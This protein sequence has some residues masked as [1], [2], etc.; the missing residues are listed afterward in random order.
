VLVGPIPELNKKVEIKRTAMGVIKR[1]VK[2][3]LFFI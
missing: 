2:N 1:I 3:V